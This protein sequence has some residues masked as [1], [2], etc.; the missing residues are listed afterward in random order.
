MPGPPA[1]WGGG[2]AG[3]RARA[4]RRTPGAARWCCCWRGGGGALLGKGGRLK[5]EWIQSVRRGSQPSTGCT[6]LHTRT[7]RPR[8]LHHRQQE[9]H[10]PLQALQGPG[11]VRGGLAVPIVFAYTL[12]DPIH[13]SYLS[14]TAPSHPPEEDGICAAS[15]SSVH[16]FSRPTNTATSTRPGPAPTSMTR[17]AKSAA[18]RLSMRTIISSCGRRSSL[19]PAYPLHAHARTHRAGGR[20]DTASRRTSD[21]RREAAAVRGHE[22]DDDDDVPSGSSSGWGRRSQRAQSARAANSASGCGFCV[23][24]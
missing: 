17:R 20:P 3:R 4:G 9:C 6:R 24:V 23:C 12:S 5:R 18:R 13:S 7:K 15:A 19:S 16:C 11:R 22:G 1:N 8:L 14:S 2:A 10:Q 21:A